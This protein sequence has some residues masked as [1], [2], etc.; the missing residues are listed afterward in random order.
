MRFDTVMMWDVAAGALV[1]MQDRQPPPG[2]LPE[3]GN[4]A[5][6][7]LAIVLVLLLATA[8]LIRNMSKRITRLPESFEP[9]EAE[10]GAESE[11]ESESEFESG[12]GADSEARS[13]AGSEIGKEQRSS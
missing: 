7:G 4:A 9:D 8:L 1:P 13:E 6:V 10:S 12:A 2:K 11:S 5:P 3:W